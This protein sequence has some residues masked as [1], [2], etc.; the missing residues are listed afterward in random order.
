MVL[1]LVVGPSLLERATLAFLSE[2][3][4]ERVRAAQ[5]FVSREG[6]VAR[7]VVIG[8]VEE[9]SVRGSSVRVTVDLSRAWRRDIS[10][11][12]IL[13]EGL[14]VSCPLDGCVLIRVIEKLAESSDV[15]PLFK[16]EIGQIHSFAAKESRFFLSDEI[17][18]LI[19]P[20]S[21]LV[22]LSTESLSA[23]SMLK[24]NSNLPL[25]TLRSLQGE[26]SVGGTLQVPLI[27]AFVERPGT[28]PSLR[29]EASLRDGKVSVTPVVGGAQSRIS[30]EIL[31]D[32]VLSTLSIVALQVSDFPA[33][34]LLEDPSGM[35]LD[36]K[37]DGSVSF[38]EFSGELRGEFE[39]RKLP[40]L[41][42]LSGKVSYDSRLGAT[43]ELRGW[44]PGG[45]VVLNLKS[46]PFGQQIKA[47]LSA[48]NF[49]L[50]EKIKPTDTVE[51]FVLQTRLE[52]V[53]ELESLS[54]SGPATIQRRVV[55]GGSELSFSQIELKLDLDVSAFEPKKVSGVVTL[56]PVSM[57]R[58]G[59]YSAK[60][61]ELSLKD[62][63]LDIP[64]FSLRIGEEELVV[65]GTIGE[66]GYN[67]S[68]R[69]QAEVESLL[70]SLTR[71]DDVAGVVIAE[72]DIKGELERP[73]I[74]GRISL[75]S[76]A[77]SVEVGSDLLSFGGIVGRV[78][79]DD[80][81]L[82][83]E[84]LKNSSGDGLFEIAGGITNFTSGNQRSGDLS[85]T[86]RSLRSAPAEGLKLSADGEGVVEIRADKVPRVRGV[87]DVSQALFEQRIDA[88]TMIRRLLESLSARGDQRV[89]GNAEL[90]VDLDITITSERGVVVDTD[91][92]QGDL[93]VDLKVATESRKPVL[94]GSV[95]TQ[96]AQ[97]MLGKS[98]LT[99]SKG[100]VRF[101][102]IPAGALPT[103]DLSAEG[104]LGVG[105]EYGQLQIVGRIDNPKISIRSESGR[106][107]REL[108]ALLMSGFEGMSVSRGRRDLSLRDIL[109]PFSG[110]GVFDRLK[111]LTGVTDVEV[112]S[113]FSSDTGEFAP[114][115]RAIRP[116]PWRLQGVAEAELTEFNR[117][118]LSLE[119]SLTD[120][121][122]LFTAWRNAP[123]TQN[124]ES[125]TG[126]FGLGIH[127][128]ERFQGAGLFPGELLLE[129]IRELTP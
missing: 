110:V 13:I 37:L 43:A 94:S 74:D 126:S 26:L 91:L 6:L 127:Y 99:V 30:G 53:G 117:S 18:V 103:I 71:L 3:F 92:L 112:E 93:S 109:N 8:D 105:E 66:E 58:Y 40:E 82:V 97:L 68:I 41:D 10:I 17:E 118:Q 15:T 95:E 111:G 20:E 7:E 39:F 19:Q 107:E 85:W 9:D 69:G 76:G 79:F 16:V 47:S 81:D 65:G 22:D 121:T 28:L 60:P 25:E 87:V 123:T 84:E 102:S 21:L 36:L 51:R 120:H 23:H 42:R 46:D 104:D 129:N 1:G 115:V 38:K 64:D 61:V 98:E 114:R 24:L 96:T 33:G 35:E 29:V 125:L 14:Q 86:V 119:Y 90:P 100:I 73:R 56:L 34:A 2:L 89:E 31:F 52:A 88:R 5:V 116:L 63:S 50:R 44:A 54:V 48:D 106:N 72:L 122:N 77:I 12:Q 108:L 4:G 78:K 67:L 113:G 45:I 101:D 49:I 27:N 124:P 128:R 59:L 62:L 83:V 80:S 70:S 57:P 55:Q 75:T 11:P 32:P